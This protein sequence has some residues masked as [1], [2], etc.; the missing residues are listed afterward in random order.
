[1]P[2]PVVRFVIQGPDLAVLRRFYS[3]AFGWELC[4]VVPTYLGIE[5]T[6]HEHDEQGN[7]V[8]PPIALQAGGG[9]LTW[10]YEGERHR[11]RYLA[12]GAD[13]GLA[14]AAAAVFVCIEVA[15]LADAIAKVERAGGTV[16]RPPRKIPH[17]TSVAQIA[18]PAGD[19]LELQQQLGA[20]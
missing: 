8:M 2:N 14:A 3:E 19:L 7:D 6:S 15:D 9:A 4:D 17:F 12:P 20:D 1:M 10:R 16:V 13:G 5:F 11:P 18:D